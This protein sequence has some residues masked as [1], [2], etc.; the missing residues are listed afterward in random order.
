MNL[1]V[2]LENSTRYFP[3]KKAIIE[4]ERVYSYSEFNDY[5][6]RIAS[7]LSDSGVKPNDY[8]G[9]CA[10]NSYDWVALYFGALKCGAVAVTFSH[11]LTKN[12]FQTILFDCKPKVL[13]VQ[14]DRLPD[15]D[16]NGSKYHPD[17][18]ITEKGNN[19]LK[20][21]AQKADPSF[22]TVD[23]DRDDIAAILYTGGTTG[24]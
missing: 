10:A 1:A 13:F 4:G 20:N 23:R 14:E 21:L 15:L 22:K 11:R 16:Y 3:D 7:A 24:T 2:I 6:T 18:I 5:A 17:L 19:S 8:V 9:F 12:E